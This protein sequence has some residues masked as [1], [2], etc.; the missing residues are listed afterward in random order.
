M[1]IS[2]LVIE[3]EKHWLVSE[4]PRWRVTSGFKV[5]RNV[6]RE[7][8]FSVSRYEWVDQDL[9]TVFCKQPASEFRFNTVIET[10]WFA[11]DHSG[12]NVTPARRTKLILVL[13]CVHKQ[14][15]IAQNT[16]RKLV[17]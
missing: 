1:I 15:Y 14:A 12:F 11:P 2:R 5:G 7:R 17:Q 13:F 8:V 16:S 4:M 6:T 10:C 3:E 9:K